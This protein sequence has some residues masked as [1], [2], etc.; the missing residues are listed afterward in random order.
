MRGLRDSIG[1]RATEIGTGVQRYRG[2]DDTTSKENE[3]IDNK[4]HYDD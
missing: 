2:D 1:C 4:S 3:N